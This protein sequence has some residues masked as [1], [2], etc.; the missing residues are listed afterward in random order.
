MRT[1][2]LSLTIV[3]LIFLSIGCSNTPEDQKK[4]IRYVK[5]EKVDIPT[6]LMKGHLMPR[7]KK[8][9]SHLWLSG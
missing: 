5:V 3:G 2:L 4:E 1:V 9:N 7:L 6:L 8:I